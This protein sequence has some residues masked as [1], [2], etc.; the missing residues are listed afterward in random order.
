MTGYP[1][2]ME[3]LANFTKLAHSRIK[4]DLIIKFKDIILPYCI[5]D[6]KLG[7]SSTTIS[8]DD[9]EMRRDEFRSGDDRY[10]ISEILSEILDDHGLDMMICG[11]HKQDNCPS[12]R[13]NQLA[14]CFCKPTAIRIFWNINTTENTED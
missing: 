4:H 2:P 8:I 14:D 12:H 3:S 10:F 6:A 11:Y 9:L 1:L 7:Y 5:R 13:N